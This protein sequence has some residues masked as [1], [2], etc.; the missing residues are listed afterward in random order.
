MAHEVCKYRLNENGTI[1]DFIY[2]GNDGIH[3]VCLV[4]DML[5]S[6][7]RDNLMIGI[8]VSNAVGDFESFGS[9]ATL[10]TYITSISGDWTQAAPTDEDP[11]AT[12]AFDAASEVTRIWDAC[13][14][15]NA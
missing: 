13:T 12:E 5:E 2:F 8:T 14:D 3:G 4:A 11:D 9:K 10:Q 1:P 15:L 6:S 7:P